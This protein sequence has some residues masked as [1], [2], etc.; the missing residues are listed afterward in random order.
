VDKNPQNETE[1]RMTRRQYRQQSNDFGS[2]LGNEENGDQRQPFSGS[3]AAQRNEQEQLSSEEKTQ[4][5][6]RKLNIAIV[7]LIIAIIIVYLILFFVK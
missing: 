7:G 6:K 4:R 3:R 5:L 1:S 2:S